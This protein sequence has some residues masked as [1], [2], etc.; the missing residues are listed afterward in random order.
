MKKSTFTET[1]N[2]TNIKAIL[3]EAL[4]QAHIVHND[5]GREGLAAEAKNRYGDMAMTVDVRCG[6]AIILYLQR[7]MFPIRLIGEESS[8][9]TIGTPKY[10]GVMDEMDG[11][12]MAKAGWNVN[13]YG[14]M[15]GIF[16]TTD[17]S[18]DDYVAV[19]YIEHATKNLYYAVNGEGAFV[20]NL[21]T[22]RTKRI[23]TS[24]KSRL[25]N[26][27]RIYVDEYYDFNVKTFSE[28]LRD[29]APNKGDFYDGTA[30][31]VSFADVA[32]GAADFS[33]RSTGKNN[34]EPMIAYGLITEAGGAMVD[35]EGNSFGPK[36]YLEY[37]QGEKL[38]IITAATPEL[39]MEMVEYLKAH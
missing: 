16:A 12:D 22:T 19:G 9:V 17:P 35:E 11:S 25:G 15:F 18:Y 13:R 39:A 24:G 7:H 30:A 5:L 31:S 6:E 29:F 32:R 28:K 21:A 38:P 3:I 14:T 36:K 37:G 34:L 33:L 4:T 23:R 2:R 1:E 8:E 10:L 27:A 26:E 20:L